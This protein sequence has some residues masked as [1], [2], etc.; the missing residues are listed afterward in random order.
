MKQF[1]PGKTGVLTLCLIL[2]LTMALALGANQPSHAASAAQINTW[3]QQ[4]LVDF[5]KSVP[6][7]EKI[8]AEAKGVLVFPRAY[9][10]GILVG[11][12]YAEGE[13]LVDNAVSGY[14]N[15][16]GLSW[17][18][19]L[20]GQRQSVVIAFMTNDALMKFRNSQGWDLGTDATV[21]I[22]DSGVQGSM[23][24]AR[25]NKPVVAFALDQKGLMAGLSLQGS[26]VTR[27]NK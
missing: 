4:T 27:V 18:W 23:S 24:V 13:L 15:M 3:T 5:K 22:I 11:G 12:K 20:G 6:D 7:A 14:Y 16:V 17:G 21:A 8:L 10:A 1:K 9:N 19:Q 2:C 25:F 26:K